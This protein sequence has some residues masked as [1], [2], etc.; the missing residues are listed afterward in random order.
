MRQR[1]TRKYFYYLYDT[2]KVEGLPAFGGRPAI[3]P[4]FCKERRTT[5][6]ECEAEVVRLHLARKQREA[7]ATEARWGFEV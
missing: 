2:G 4:R 6:A 5:L 3:Y 7:D 1:A